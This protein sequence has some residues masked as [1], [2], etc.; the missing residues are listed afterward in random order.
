MFVADSLVVDAPVY[1]TPRPTVYTRFGDYLPFALAFGIMLFLLAR[2]LAER[3]ST[4]REED[5]LYC[6]RQ[7]AVDLLER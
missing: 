5:V 3:L 2:L 7:D 1:R 6:E 4:R